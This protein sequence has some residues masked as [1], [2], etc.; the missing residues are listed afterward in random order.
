MVPMMKY[1]NTAA[2]LW[3]PCETK[4]TAT[5]NGV[6]ATATFEDGYEKVTLGSGTYTVVPEQ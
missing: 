4:G 6:P 1:K 3:L 5:V 2:T